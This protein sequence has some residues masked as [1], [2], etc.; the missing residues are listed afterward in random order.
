MRTGWGTSWL[1]NKG[2]EAQVHVLMLAK[3]LAEEPVIDDHDG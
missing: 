3:R 2:D 1:T